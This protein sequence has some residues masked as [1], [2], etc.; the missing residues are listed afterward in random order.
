MV[1]G[2][3]KCKVL[4]MG[5]TFKENVSDIRNSKVADLVY[6]LMGFRV[7]VDVVDPHA[8]AEEVKREYGLA[9][10]KKTSGPYDA[11]IMAVGHNVFF[12]LDI[13]DLKKDLTKDAVIFDLKGVFQKHR[14]QGSNLLESVMGGSIAYKRLSDNRCS[15]HEKELRWFA[16]RTPYKREKTALK[17]LIRLGI[18]CYL[19]V[20]HVVSRYDRKIKV[21]EKP[22]INNYLFVRISRPQYI[23]VLQARDVIEFVKFTDEII[24]I[25]TEEIALLRRI[26][27]ATENVALSDRLPQVGTE[28]EIIAGKLTGIRGKVTNVLGK[29]AFLVDLKTLGWTL[30]IEVHP[31]YLRA[32]C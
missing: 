15:L 8:D 12:S 17:E 10:S 30:Q 6:E 14:D 13:D 11:V 23:S 4:V 26:T 31:K 3:N 24:A 29:K 20:I 32:I 5:M 25:P 16:I 1:K 21:Y 9:L 27:G 2:P 18:E 7:A 28:V 22:L 19:P